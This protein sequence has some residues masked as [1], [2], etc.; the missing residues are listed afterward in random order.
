MGLSKRE[1]K[2]LWCFVNIGVLLLG[3]KFVL[4]EVNQYYRASEETL[5][6]NE[7]NA[8]QAEILLAKEKELPSRLEQ[9]K[10]E[11]NE[12]EAYYF[13]KLD[14]EYMETW[15]MNISQRYPIKIEALTMEEIRMQDEEGLVEVLPIGM[16]IQGDEQTIIDF[17]NALLNDRR[18]VVLEQLEMETTK[19]QIKI[20]VYRTEKEEDELDKILFNKPL[21][22]DH[23][24][25]PASEEIS[26]SEQTQ[27]PADNSQN[28]SALESLITQLM[29]PNQE[30]VQSEKPTASDEDE[31]VSTDTEAQN[32][33]E[34]EGDGNEA[35]TKNA[36]ETT[37]ADNSQASSQ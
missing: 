35:S 21:G 4:P 17:I 18:H 5:Q 13:S 12:E 14:S 37:Q 8:L 32:K 6:T 23:L 33:E 29:R 16:T 3:V 34:T 31:V 24:M 26:N 1:K 9:Y 30:G 36:A 20:G 2:L 25:K 19:V 15:I 7:F 10:E 28:L 11:L 22:K 27:V